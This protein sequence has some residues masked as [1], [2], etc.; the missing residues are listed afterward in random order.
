LPTHLFFVLGLRYEELH[1][2]WLARL[3]QMLAQ[4]AIVPALLEADGAA[5]IYEILAN[6][7][8]KLAPRASSARGVP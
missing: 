6:A 1:L 2:P 7:D 3:V 4:H 5:A 8:R